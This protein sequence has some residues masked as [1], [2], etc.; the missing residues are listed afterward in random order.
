MTDALVEEEA[1]PA[2]RKLLKAYLA[3][4][5]LPLSRRRVVKGTFPSG[6]NARKSVRHSKSHKSDEGHG[7]H[8]PESQDPRCVIIISGKLS[9]EVLEIPSPR[10]RAVTLMLLTYNR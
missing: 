4:P 7:L 3:A 9:L 1:A 2:A 6:L 8:E 5:R 10:I